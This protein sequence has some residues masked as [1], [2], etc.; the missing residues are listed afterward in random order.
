M[1]IIKKSKLKNQ[2]L[3][4]EAALLDYYKKNKRL[5]CPAQQNLPQTD[6]NYAKEQVV[7][8]SCTTSLPENTCDA[9]KVALS[10]NAYIGALP[11]E[12]LNLGKNM[13][14][15]PWGRKLLMR[16]IEFLLVR[17]MVLLQKFL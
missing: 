11:V 12:F 4:I 1:S 14:L 5:P 17:M 15:D 10:N 13:M 3:V 9:D 8:Y 6:A 7:N 2:L 16:L